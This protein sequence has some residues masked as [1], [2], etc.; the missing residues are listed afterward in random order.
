MIVIALSG[1][2]GSGKTTIG[3]IVSQHFNLKFISIGSLFREM[4]HELNVSLEEFHRMAENDPKYDLMVDSRALEEARKGNVLIEGHLACWI[5]KDIADIKIYLMAPLEERAK[6]IAERDNLSLE[7]AIEEIKKREESNRKRY[8]EIYGID[9][10]DLSIMD[11]VINTSKFSREGVEKI[12]ISIIE[13]YLSNK[14]AS[15]SYDR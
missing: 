12:L 10:N 11:F 8:K 13:A 1:L 7:K 4:A 9:I 15:V 3:K 2:A 14:N 5:L 6:R